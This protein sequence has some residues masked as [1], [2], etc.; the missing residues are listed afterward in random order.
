MARA[1]P[2]W[3]TKLRVQLV[4]LRKEQQALERKLMVPRLM[5]EGH[6]NTQY[7]RCGKS[8][9]RCM[10][11]HDPIKHGPYHYQAVQTENGLRLKYLKE[12]S[13]VEQLK[14]YRE[15]NGWLSTYRKNQ[16][17]MASLFLEMKK[18]SCHE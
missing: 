15:Y 17:K 8:N 1:A 9:C 12:T 2:Q 10:G 6:L 4:A 11:K 3:L 13:V 16:E 7:R 5:K 18:R 14:R